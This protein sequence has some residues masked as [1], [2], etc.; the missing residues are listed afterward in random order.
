MNRIPSIFR[1]LGNSIMKNIAVSSQNF[2]SNVSF[3]LC[4]SLIN[5]IFFKSLRGFFFFFFFDHFKNIHHRKFYCNLSLKKSF[6]S[7]EKCFYFLSLFHK[8]LNTKLL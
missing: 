5:L 2:S 4:P 1:P 3:I 8:K 7:I 6:T